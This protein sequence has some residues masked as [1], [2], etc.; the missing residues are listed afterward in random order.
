MYVN[1]IIACVKRR[2]LEGKNL[3]DFAKVWRRL[4]RREVS[5]EAAGFSLLDPLSENCSKRCVS[6]EVSRAE[7]KGAANGTGGRNKDVKRFE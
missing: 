5:K 1:E 6:R 2:E 7:E 3:Q 4:K